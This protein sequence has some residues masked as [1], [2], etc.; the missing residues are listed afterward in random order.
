MGKL[1]G[2]GLAHKPPA[3]GP[4]QQEPGHGLFGACDAQCDPRR[5]EQDRRPE[6]EGGENKIIARRRAMAFLS[7]GQLGGKVVAQGLLEECALAFAPDGDQPWRHDQ[8]RQSHAPDRPG[9]LEPGPGD[10]RLGP[11]VPNQKRDDGGGGDPGDHRSLDQDAQGERRPTPH[12]QPGRDRA[13]PPRRRDKFAAARPGCRSRWP[14]GPRRWW[15]WWPRLSAAPR[16]QQQR[17]QQPHLGGEDR[18]A[19]IGQPHRGDAAHQRRQAIGP[20]LVSWPSARFST[21]PATAVA[22]ACIQ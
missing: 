21:W 19:P 5:H 10:A 9:G 2:D 16:S 11:P 4:R 6:G 14:A 22:A 17:R 20:Y 3:P 1:G 18:T 13:F 15:R 12:H 7:A 8:K